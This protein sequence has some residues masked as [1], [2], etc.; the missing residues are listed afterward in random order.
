MEWNSHERTSQ[1]KMYGKWLFFEDLDV[2]DES[3]NEC[4]NDIFWG[5]NYIF[6]LGCSKGFLKTVMTIEGD[7]DYWIRLLDFSWSWAMT[8]SCDHNIAI[9]LR[10]VCKE[11]CIWLCAIDLSFL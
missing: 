2:R 8:K 6:G 5:K 11:W 3:L 4:G 9:N 10:F 7:Q 1:W